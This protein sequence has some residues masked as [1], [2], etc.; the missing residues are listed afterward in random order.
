MKRLGNVEDEINLIYMSEMKEHR[1]LLLGTLG[2]HLVLQFR[3]HHSRIKKTVVIRSD[4]TYS[5]F[6]IVSSGSRRRPVAKRSRGQGD[7]RFV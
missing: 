2:R 3:F 5:R 6:M 7:E 1:S 4:C